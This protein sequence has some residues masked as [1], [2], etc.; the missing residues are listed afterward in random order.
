MNNVNFSPDGKVSL[1]LQLF[2]I[3]FYEAVAISFNVPIITAKQ[4]T[5]NGLTDKRNNL[6]E[7]VA[8]QFGL[9]INK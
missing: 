9:D 1:D 7:L 8:E 6:L 4:Y 5:L 2:M 3:S